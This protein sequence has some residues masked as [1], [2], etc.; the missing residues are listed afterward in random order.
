MGKPAARI[1]DMHTCPMVTG[2]V[3]HVGGAIVL[4]SFNVFTGKLPQARVGD[5]AVCVGPPDV[6]AMGS[7]GVFVNKRPAAR[8]GDT[9]AHGG[10][11]VVGLPTVLIGEKGGGGGGGG[12]GPMAVG[13]ASRGFT[14]GGVPNLAFADA[15]KMAQAM[16]EAARNGTPFCEVCF[17]NKLKAEAD[18]PA[19]SKA[20]PHATV[21]QPPPQ[22]PPK[23]AASKVCELTGFDLHCSHG[24]RPGPGGVLMVVPGSEFGGDAI[25][26]ALQIKGGCGD[27]PSW[28]VTG[29]EGKQG[30]SASLDF[31]ALRS[32]LH[33][34][35]LFALQGASPNVY[36]VEAH[37]C[38]G[39]R[40]VEVHA[41]P[42]GQVSY[43]LGITKLV[44]RIADLIKF[45]PIEEAQK[46]RWEKEWFQGSAG[47]EGGWKEEEGSWRAYYEKSW[48]VGYDPLFGIKHH[49]PIYPLTLV[50]GWL[51]KW[52]KAGLFIEIGFSAKLK[53]T[54][55]G[56]YWPTDSATQWGT[57]T[58]SG[59]GDGKF[60][61]SV[62]AMLWDEDVAEVILAGE[63]GAG[64]ELG[65]TDGEETEVTL[66]LKHA[67]VKGI[68]TVKAVYGVVEFKR[69]F[70]LVSAGEY[71]KHWPLAEGG[72]APVGFKG[73]GATGDIN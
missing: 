59:G 66:T 52:V 34:S 17:L 54:A 16:T 50:P 69:E 70:Q 2:V 73:G 60:A 10:V 47:F 68:A 72:A 5:M 38:A 21:P 64:L 71:V 25:S 8:M 43:A 30:K 63:T 57:R 18:K 19:P 62:E 67:G 7:T 15:Q 36:R 45:L 23:P 14:G 13:L 40:A 42:P 1:S 44:E 28:V 51:E 27:H 48:S 24:R 37:G 56:R 9:T 33:A 3:P 12:A 35:E 46:K 6:I 39:G 49:G 41:Y 11:I 29:P 58:V 4:G 31:K 32:G 22:P 26:G 53:V 65:R 20:K 61:L 55:K